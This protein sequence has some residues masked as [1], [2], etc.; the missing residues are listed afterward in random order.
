MTDTTNKPPFEAIREVLDHLWEA[1]EKDCQEREAYGEE[2]ENHIFYSLVE[3][4]SWLHACNEDRP[5]DQAAIDRLEQQ[6]RRSGLRWAMG[7]YAGA[8]LLTF[9]FL[10]WGRLDQCF[11]IAACA[12]SLAKGAVWSAVWPIYW[13]LPAQPPSI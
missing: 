4:R 9:G 11:G 1:E 8:A 5:S 12:I 13:S 7:I 2:C 3:I 6:V 10:T